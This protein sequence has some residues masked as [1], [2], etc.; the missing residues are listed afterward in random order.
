MK[1]FENTVNVRLFIL[2]TSIIVI[3]VVVWN[4][5]VF[6]EGV[7]NEEREKMRIWSSAQASVNK[8][9]EE[10]DLN[11]ELEILNTI[12]DIPMFI[13][14]DSNGFQEVNNIP[15][16]ITSDSLRLRQYFESIK[17]QNQPIIIDLGEAGKQY[18][19]YG[20]SS[21]L[22]KIKYYPFILLLI[23]F[24]LLGLIY[25][26]Y[27][28]AKNS[29]KNKLWAGM[30]KETA[31]QIGTPLSSLVGWMEILRS[32][33]VNPEYIL[34]I[35]K[36]IDRLKTITERFSK[37]GSKLTL[38]VSS[39]NKAVENSFNYLKDR[40]SKLIQFSIELPEEDFKCK[41]NPT[42]LSWTIE[43]LTKNAIDAMKGR[44]DLKISLFEDKNYFKI[45]VSDTGK[46]IPSSKF[47]TIF[48]PG[49]STKERGWGLGLSLS[50]RIIEDYH[51]GKIKVLSSS[52][53]SGTVFEIKLPKN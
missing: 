12:N 27:V 47:K 49:Y 43:N 4:I 22:T 19:Y 26:Y 25:L 39:L 28:T 34:D 30:A 35:E 40:S 41:L 46:G 53:E 37:V 13:V 6:Y 15:E 52:S 48:Q 32:E 16:T 1:F 38:E 10:Q 14:N 36:D 31:H 33:N 29:E 5:S 3:G 9:G 17:N 18:L 8:A 45:H 11:L 7:K 20:D 21:I 44:G 51:S 50:K 23:I 24:L 42:L 2:F